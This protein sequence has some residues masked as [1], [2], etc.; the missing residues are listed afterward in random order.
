MKNKLLLKLSCGLLLLSTLPLYSCSSNV[1]PFEGR[2]LSDGKIGLDYSENIA[3]GTFDM[4]YDL[5]YD[6]SLPEGLVLYDDGLIKGNPKEAGTFQFKAVMIDLND[7]EYYAD[8]SI[9]IEPGEIT[10]SSFDLPNGKV[11]EPYIQNLAS[12][13]GMNDISYSLKEGSLLPKGLA[14]SLDGILSGIPEEVSES[15]FTVVASSK[16]ANDKEAEF[17]VTIEPGEKKE[18]DLGHIVFDDFDLP[19]GLVGSEYNQSIRK[20]YGA[21]NIQYAFRF[22][23]SGGLPSGL[24][25]DKNLGI[26]SGTPKD[27]TEGVIKFRVIAS[28]EGCESVTANITMRIDD[29]YVSTSKFETEYVDSIPHL[30]GAG[31]SSSPSGRGMIQK[32]PKA[33]NGNVLGYLNKPTTV[34]FK[35]QSEKETD[36]TLSIGLGS[37]NG[38]FDYNSSK[39]GIKING[40]ELNYGSFHVNQIGSTESDFECEKHTLSPSIKLKAGENLL[41]F[42]IKKSDEATGTFSAVGCLFDYIEIENANGEIGWRPRVANV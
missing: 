32:M 11:N 14:L 12:A 41:S 19:S 39:F 18:E 25:A 8:F 21:K 24:K 7:K 31:Y 9:Y 33:S 28:A 4:Y 1:K 13:S 2:K 37:E 30:S 3:N 38:A 26:I 15:T 36:C 23:S 27:S 34:I 35:I 5:D 10:Y 22:S 40:A 17:K 29:V 42:E 6:S 20:A 16:G